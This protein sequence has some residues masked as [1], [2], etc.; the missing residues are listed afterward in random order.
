MI[1]YTLNG[2]NNIVNLFIYQFLNILKVKDIKYL[3][4]T[5]QMRSL[6]LL[7]NL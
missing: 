1:T 3:I 2:G 6:F 5:F 4:E 7:I